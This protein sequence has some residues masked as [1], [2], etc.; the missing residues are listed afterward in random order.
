LPR[1][2][3]R[4]SVLLLSRYWGFHTDE[5]SKYL[6][7]CAYMDKPKEREEHDPPPILYNLS[8]DPSEQFIM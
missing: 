1:D 7:T 6:V 8:Q 5:I 4:K 2:N 3:T